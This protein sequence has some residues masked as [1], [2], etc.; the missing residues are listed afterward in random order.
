VSR[1]KE[2]LVTP[3]APPTTPIVYPR[4]YLGALHA[5][6]GSGAFTEARDQR[7]S[8]LLHS[9]LQRAQEFNDR[10]LATE[11]RTFTNP[12]PAEVA[13]GRTTLAGGAVMRITRESLNELAGHLVD[14][15]AK[16]SGIGRD[17]LLF[18]ADDATR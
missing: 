8:I 10:L 12:T 6:L 13:L 15:Y 5:V 4:L 7:L 17:T 14:H 16:E 18:S 11:T 9:W 1:G 3:A 2:F